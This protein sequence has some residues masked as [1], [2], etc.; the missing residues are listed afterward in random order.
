[1]EVRLAQPDDLREL[2]AL[3]EEF[4]ASQVALGAPDQRKVL[5]I[6]MRY[7]IENGEAV[8]VAE[9]DGKLVGFVAWV[10]LPATADGV[11][12]GLGTF[13]IPGHRRE[14]ISIALREFALDHC[15]KKGHQFVNVGIM[16]NN[17]AGRISAERQG[18]QL[19]GQ[20]YRWVL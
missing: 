11:V 4:V 5:A 12:D 6:G 9:L 17:I 20:I 19:M 2:W 7:G 10:H 13:V 18:A 8:V 1:M 16:A 15:R 3:A 14:R